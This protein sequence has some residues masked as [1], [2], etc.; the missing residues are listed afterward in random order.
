M[1][2]FKRGKKS[3]KPP[4]PG[5]ACTFCG[6]RNTILISLHGSDADNPVRTWRGQRYLTCR[7]L[8]CGRD[9]YGAAGSTVTQDNFPDDERLVDNEDELKA[10]EDALKKE[11]GDQDDRMFG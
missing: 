2:P 1:W 6:S 3:A 9:F 4:S 11:I 8:D 7:C 5:T 10:A